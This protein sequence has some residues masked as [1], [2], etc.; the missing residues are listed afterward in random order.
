MKSSD[1]FNLILGGIGFTY[2]DIAQ[3]LFLGYQEAETA[4]LSK[5]SDPLA[6]SEPGFI[7]DLYGIR[8]RTSN[9]WPE[10]APHD[11]AFTGIPV[12]GN[13]H[14]EAMEWIAIMRSVLSAS[15]HYAIMELG[16]G[17]G[18]ACVSGLV[19]ARLKGIQHRYALAVE[20]DPH[21]LRFLKEHLSN[22]CIEPDQYGIVEGA[23]GIENGSAEWPDGD[24]TAVEYGNRPITTAGDHLGRD[25]PKTRTVDLYAIDELLTQR[26]EWD[27][28]HVDI[29]GLE[30]DVLGSAMARLNERVAR[31]CI[32]TH[33]R[34]I[35]GDLYEM[36]ALQGWMLE[37]EKPTKM[38][39]VAGAKTLEVMT[40]VDGTQV[41][42]NP[43]LRPDPVEA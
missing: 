26:P 33:S 17:W 16:A 14:W 10:M 41:W 37:H 1:Q 43:R 4:L 21:H 30:V 7:T 23:V 29:Q 39:F 25:I 3:S 28:L 35:D 24:H 19:L 27:M 6:K 13:F 18:P 11:G 2:D 15:D 12:P 9:L 42:R 36:F 34:K 40:S 20:A 32:G 31:T 8:T 5:L 38:T 22:N